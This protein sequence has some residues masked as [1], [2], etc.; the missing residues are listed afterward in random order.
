MRVY[1][2]KET[3]F[4]GRLIVEP[5]HQNYGIGTILMQSI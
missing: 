3:S 4:I 1:P 2:E 5:D